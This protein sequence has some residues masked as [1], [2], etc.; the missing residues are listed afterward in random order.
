M[1]PRVAFGT[2]ALLVAL[3]GPCAAEVGGTWG[4]GFAANYEVP[5]FKLNAWFPSGGPQLGGTVFYVVNDTWTTEVEFHWSKFGGGDLEKRSFLWSVD[6]N[7]YT[8]PNAKSEMTW[9]SGVTNFIRHFGAGGSKLETGGGAPYALIGA[10]FY[11]YANDISGLVFPAQNATPLDTSILLRPVSDVRTA[12][13]INLGLGV[14][15]F[16]SSSLAIDFRG[17]YNIVMGT[18][19]GLEAWGLEEVFPFQKLNVGV[20]LKFYLEG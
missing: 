5:V 3:S 10:G 6:R 19:R 13:G 12:L 20:R 11:H 17:Q 9:F 8:S 4:V 1:Q 14:E 15:Y 2:L 7:E 16:A 18:V